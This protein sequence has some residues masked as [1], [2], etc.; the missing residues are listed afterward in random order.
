[1]LKI[2]REKERERERKTEREIYDVK[3]QTW[4][5]KKKFF[6]VKTLSNLSLITS[7]RRIYYC[8]IA[9]TL[10][11]D[12]TLVVVELAVVELALVELASMWIFVY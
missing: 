10:N 9:G 1:M 3:N 12:I 11:Y 4:I 2:Y 7:P 8:S 6:V 5:L